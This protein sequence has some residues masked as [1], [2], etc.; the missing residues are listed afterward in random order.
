MSVLAR[1]SDR[2]RGPAVKSFRV[3]NWI[4]SKATFGDLKTHTKQLDDQYRTYVNRYGPGL[5]IYWFGH[6]AELPP[7]PDVL[8]MDH[9]PRPEELLTLTSLSMGHAE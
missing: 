2:G 5:V 9:F 3:V 4:D 6:L 1:S 7:D 8:V